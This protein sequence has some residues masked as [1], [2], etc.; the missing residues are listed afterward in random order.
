HRRCGA[1]HCGYPARRGGIGGSDARRA[2]MEQ[3]V[4]PAVGSRMHRRSS[5]GGAL[6]TPVWRLRNGLLT[7][8]LTYAARQKINSA[9]EPVICGDVAYLGV[10]CTRQA[11]E[12]AS[13]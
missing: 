2:N 11:M 13:V 7:D 4:L 6:M 8:G 1:D 3:G 9:D 5:R 10:R 12:E